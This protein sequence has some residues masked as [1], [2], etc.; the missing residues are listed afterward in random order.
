MT[1]KKSFYLM[2]LITLVFV[3][4]CEPLT[5]EE[6]DSIETLTSA[7]PVEEVEEIEEILEEIELEEGKEE[8]EEKI[9]EEPVK[10]EVKKVEEEVE[11]EVEETTKESTVRTKTI[12]IENMQLYPSNNVFIF[13][14]TEVV[15]QNK[16]PLP[17]KISGF[18]FDSGTMNQGDEFRHK[19]TKP[20]KYGFTDEFH[21]SLGGYVNVIDINELGLDVQ[22][23]DEL[24]WIL[25][26]H[27]KFNPSTANVKAGQTVI[28][29]NEDPM[30]HSV[31]GLGFEAVLLAGKKFH[32]KFDQIGTYLYECTKHENEKGKIVVS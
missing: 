9:E 16:D 32:K 8:I 2:F 26:K 24:V 4:G 22:N 15:W 6:L 14:D 19:F 10:I 17:H 12:L 21:P 20:G 25:I 13:P 28:W 11:E 1:F 27:Y 5:F 31:K 18:R 30:A 3:L 29:E 23:A 7:V